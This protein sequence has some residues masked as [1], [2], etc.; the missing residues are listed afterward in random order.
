M[1]LASGWRS[2]ARGALRLLGA[3]LGRPLVGPR[4]VG[5][6]ITHL[7]N[8]HCG[9][10]ESHGRLVSPSIDKRR[11]Y[12]G[13]RRAMELDTVARLSRSLARLGIEWVELSGKGDATVHP[14]LPEVIRRLKGAGLRC[15]IFANGTVHRPGLVETLVE[16]RVERVNLSLNAASRP[17]FARVTGK[18]LWDE[19]V[20]F[21]DRT[22][23]LR[24]AAGRRRPWV[25][26][27]FVVCRDNL[28]DMDG[29]VSLCCGRGVDEGGW[30]IMGEIP[31]TA[32]LQLDC[33]QA[34][35]LLARIP[36]WAR[37]LEASGV[38]HDLRIF[39]EDL[40][41]RIGRGA[42]QDN[43]LQ[44]GLPCYEGWLHTV[45]GPDGTVVPCCYCEDAQLGNVV[46][47][48]FERIWRGERYRDFRRRAL[49]IPR[50]GRPICREC[51]TSCNR[52]QDNRY[53]HQRLRA[54]GLAR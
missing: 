51:F 19:A 38:A 23:A 48:D 25:R 7:C 3:G 36:E 8:L 13:G 1:H 2:R 53:V 44:R 45:I 21:L 52:A 37:R 32:P 41:L 14:Q 42:S 22:L 18:D 47:E 26:V 27:T 43:P 24:R 16:S 12:A 6:E 40:R 28:E 11:S 31:E 33:A 34:D 20:E 15:S 4:V 9:F 49:A 39:A 30:S 50:T 10:C 54:V 35:A 5:L 29:M 17:V 46:D